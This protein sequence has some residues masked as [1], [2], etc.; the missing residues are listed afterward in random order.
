MRDEGAARGAFQDGVFNYRIRVGWGDCDPAQIAY[1][2]RLPNFGLQTID[3]WWEALM[4]YGWY[5][6]N[7][8]KGFGTPFVHLSCDFRA[9]VTPRHPLICKLKPVKLGTRSLEFDFAGFQDGV[10]CYDGRYVSAFV[11]TTTFR[12][13]AAP[14][15]VRAAIEPL[16]AA[17]GTVR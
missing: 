2:A 10:H 1:T 6:M 9:P 5:E 17:S 13:I 12:P 8:D 7:R 14:E 4:G 16:V 15:D 11:N 3:A